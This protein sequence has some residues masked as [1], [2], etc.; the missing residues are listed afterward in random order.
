MSSTLDTTGGSG[1]HFKMDSLSLGGHVVTGVST[2]EMS[3]DTPDSY[4]ISV[5][6]L[7]AS[8]DR[9]RK[10][11]DR[12]DPDNELM[13]DNTIISLSIPNPY[14]SRPEEWVL[15]NWFIHEQKLTCV[16]GYLDNHVVMGNGIFTSDGKY[17]LR[18]HV[19]SVESGHLVLVDSENVVIRE[20]TTSGMHSVELTIDDFTLDAVYLKGVDINPNECIVLA[21]L[22]VHKIADRFYTYFVQKIKDLSTV[23]AEEY[24]KKEVFTGEL[25]KY[26]D[27]LN[28]IADRFSKTMDDHLALTNP[29]RVDPNMIGAAP[30]NHTHA[31]YYDADRLSEWSD[32]KLLNYADKGHT[33]AEYSTYAAT[34]AAITTA[35]QCAVDT[36]QQLSPVSI[37]QAPAGILPEQ[38][39]Q[40]TI[41]APIQILIPTEVNHPI[42]SVYDYDSGILGASRPELMEDALDLFADASGDHFAEV[43]VVDAPATFVQRFHTPREISGYRV[44]SSTSSS[45]SQIRKWTVSINNHVF[46]HTVEDP[47]LVTTSNPDIKSE[48]F[49]FDTP[50][51]VS[52]FIFTLFPGSDEDLPIAIKV[53]PIYSEYSD[54]E[55]GITNEQFELV[56]PSDG[57]SKV[58]TVPAQ[59]KPAILGIPFAR[60]G[61]PG[62][63]YAKYAAQQLEYGVSL[64]PPEYGNSREGYPFLLGKYD[65]VPLV[66]NRFSDTL[67]GDLY[68]E[69]G[70]NVASLNNIYKENGVG[71]ETSVGVT[72][73]TIIQT[74]NNN[75]VFCTGYRLGWKVSKLADL[76][77]SWTLTIE[78]IDNNDHLVTVIADGV[79]NFIPTYSLESTDI[80]Y[81][82][83]FV[84]PLQIRR[85]LLTIRTNKAVD[86]KI[87]LNQFSLYLSKYFYSV[88]RNTMYRGTNSSPITFLGSVEYLG[89]GRGL[90]VRNLCLGRTTTVPI[91]NFNP[92]PVGKL[93]NIPNPFFSA[94]VTCTPH[95][96]NSATGSLLVGTAGIKVINV[97]WDS[98]I[99]EVQEEHIYALTIHRN[100]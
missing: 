18:I 84:T 63:I 28:A 43:N 46:A 69:S 40:S 72:N 66:N 89:D 64:L 33:H 78:G 79:D 19:L 55:I 35:V 74:I 31:E 65:D 88:P 39:S 73:A 14:F 9:L 32:Q 49:N 90:S 30:D 96:Y 1:T 12:L 60:P 2:A 11:I 20:I 51:T 99:V 48:I 59:L 36:I 75:D 76:P 41:S 38:Y 22:G 70:D 7:R 98:I 45:Y 61:L 85:V 86:P 47:V 57:N 77:V 25:E 81:H 34:V 42:N 17:L 44:T 50:K 29:H 54:Y 53:S 67:L 100:W 91:D 56:I 97:A 6:A 87:Y 58:V 92:V 10:Q 24:L 26:I 93:C 82:K 5:A 37:T 4:L 71:W 62:Y 21:S 52:A 83:K 16:G 23:D 13:Q 80:L 95:A 68:L 15:K 3:K 27:Q 8:Y 94:D